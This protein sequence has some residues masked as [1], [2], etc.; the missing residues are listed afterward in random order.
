LG[1]KNPYIYELRAEVFRYS[2]ENINTGIDEVD[3][4]EDNIAYTIKLALGA[5]SGNYNIGEKITQGST[6]AK[7]TDWDSTTKTLSVINIIGAFSVGSTV[8]GSDSAASYYVSTIDELGENVYYDEF[9]NGKI[10]TEVADFIDL[11]EI[12]PFGMP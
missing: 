5:G 6:S 9:D 12:N 8:V 2:Q 7:V 1:N 10:Q 4:V 11:T 3:G